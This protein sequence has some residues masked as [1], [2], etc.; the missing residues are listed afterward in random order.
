MSNFLTR[1]FGLSSKKIPQKVAATKPVQ[2]IAEKIETKI[3][4]VVERTRRS[5][6][7][8]L[9][10]QLAYGKWY[11]GVDET[12]QPVVKKTLYG[13]EKRY[14]CKDGGEVVVSYYSRAD[15]SSNLSVTKVGNPKDINKGD[16]YRGFYSEIAVKNYIDRF[17]EN[18]TQT[19]KKKGARKQ[20]LSC[21]NGQPT[22]E[23]HEPLKRW[24]I[25]EDLFGKRKENSD[26]ISSNPRDFDRFCD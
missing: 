2:I 9:G 14:P 11:Y 20:I 3:E 1:L 17:G 19:V 5:Y 16:W 8:T 22:E 23:V 15:K 4:P 24:K 12:A 25:I 21:R 7:P 18:I 13:I 10:N 26:I 6:A